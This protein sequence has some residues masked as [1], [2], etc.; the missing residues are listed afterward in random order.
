MQDYPRWNG[1][2]LSLQPL[3]D[4]GSWPKEDGKELGLNGIVTLN[5]ERG[6]RNR[7]LWYCMSRTF[8]SSLY[9][10]NPENLLE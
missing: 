6:T 8:S 5:V 3:G 2:R 10:S 1:F 7:Q 9:A 4:C